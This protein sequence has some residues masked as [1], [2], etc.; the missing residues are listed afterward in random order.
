VEQAPSQRPV[1]STNVPVAIPHQVQR[2]Q[3][4]A[5]LK[6]APVKPTQP[7]KAKPHVAAPSPV[8]PAP[9][10]GATDSLP[11]AP[12]LTDAPVATVA[13]ALDDT[14]AAVGEAGAPL[15]PALP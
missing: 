7:K 3:A 5:K 6:A 2:P 14:L 11:T 15:I 9:L 12:E 1:S 4:S 10:E 8:E 13:K